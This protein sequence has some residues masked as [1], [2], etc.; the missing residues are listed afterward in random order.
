MQVQKIVLCLLYVIWVSIVSA[1]RLRPSS[2]FQVVM[3]FRKYESAI[4]LVGF[5]GWDIN[6]LQVTGQRMCTKI[7]QIYVPNG[8]KLMSPSFEQSKTVC[9]LDH[10]PTVIRCVKFKEK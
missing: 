3:N 4:L 2:Q 1:F 6:P 10:T 7:A 5:R 9:T 8:H